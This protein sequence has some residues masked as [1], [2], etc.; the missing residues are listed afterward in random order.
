MFMKFYIKLLQISYY[1]YKIF[2]KFMKIQNSQNFFYKIY[3]TSLQM[4]IEFTQVF[5]VY[6]TIHKTNKTLFTA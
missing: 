6:E 2:I 3:E 5:L 4:F 1:G